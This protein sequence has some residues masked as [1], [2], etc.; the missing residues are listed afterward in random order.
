[1]K[2]LCLC[3]YDQS[4]FDALS[5]SELEAIGPACRPHDEALR[6][7][8]RLMLVGSLA[9]PASSRTVRPRGGK[10]SVREGPFA[11]TD[12]PLGAFF[13]IEAEDMDEAVEVASKHP[14]AHLG[15]YFG[16]GIEMRPIDMLD[17]PVG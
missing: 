10:P 6:G 7:R 5:E 13:I 3:Y 16:G 8:G 14:G 15:A 2:Y 17:Q 11:P 12:E 9:L 1:M 4:E